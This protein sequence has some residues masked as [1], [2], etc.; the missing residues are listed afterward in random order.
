MIVKIQSDLQASDS[1]N[2]GNVM[3]GEKTCEYASEL[4]VIGKGLLRV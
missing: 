4:G 3:K 1:L 2:I